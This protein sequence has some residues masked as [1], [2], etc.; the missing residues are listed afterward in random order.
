MKKIVL[1]LTLS[2]FCSIV[3]TYAQ[4]Q[5]ILFVLSSED[6]LLLNKG[7][8]ERQTGV[9]LNE[10]FLAYKAIVSEGYVVDFATP[11]GVKA[12]IDQESINDDYWKESPSLKQEATDFWSNNEQFSNPMT[13]EEAIQRSNEYVGIVIPG[14]QGLMVDLYYDPNVPKLL[15]S[16]AEKEKAIGLICHAPALIATIPEE[17]NPFVGYTVN[18]VTPLEEFYI[19]T[20]IMKG[21]PKNRKI[22]RQL[23]KLGLKYVK[24][25]P[26]KGY[27]VRDRNLVTSQN[28]YSSTDFNQ[29]FLALLSEY[30]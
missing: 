25:G 1:L 23:K 15:T 13:L 22:A 8:K 3:S 20:F 21:K 12:T 18:S 11:N 2:G 5:K 4:S 19:E 24:G 17:K 7:K 10:F 28:P 30:K 6:T 14:G 27:A 29:K 9:F 16:F 26:G